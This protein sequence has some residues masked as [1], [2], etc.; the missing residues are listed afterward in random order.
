MA[1][2]CME[3]PNPLGAVVHRLL[4][5]SSQ[6]DLLSLPPKAAHALR[7]RMEAE[8][9]LSARPSDWG[10]PRREGDEAFN[11]KAREAWRAIEILAGRHANG[12]G[13]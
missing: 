11:W 2:S 5:L 1:E 6:A 4:S 12:K 8:E 13:P 7:S 10:L 3:E 9:M